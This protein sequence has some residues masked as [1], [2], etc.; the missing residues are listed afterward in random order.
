MLLSPLALVAPRRTWPSVGMICPTVPS[1]WC[2]PASTRPPRCRGC[3]RPCRTGT[4]RWWSTTT[5]PTAP[6]RWPAGTAPRWSPNGGPGTDRRCTPGW[7]RRRRRSSRS[8]TPTARWIPRELPA[9]VGELDR[10][11]DM[12]IGRRRP[13]PGLRWP[14]HA[15]LGTAAVCWRL[16][17]RY[18]LPVHDIAPMRVARRDALLAL[19]ITDRRTG[20]PVELMVRAARGGLDGRRTRCAAT[21]RAPAASRRSA[22]R[23]AAVSMRDWTSGGRSRDTRDPGCDREGAGRRARRR[24]GWPSPSAIRP[25]RTSPRPH[26]WTRSTPSMRRRWQARVVAITGDLG[27]AS[28]S[29]QIRSRLADLAVVEQRGDEFSARLANAHHR[30]SAGGG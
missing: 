9:L 8:S 25:R 6:P 10:G 12:A 17:T 19:G 5:A 26:C 1:R 7:R 22:D 27:Q 3:S 30:R 21:G 20:Y 11:A 18:G 23:C 14:W 29:R 16:R 24:R 2:C 28:G 13:V 15:R 4:G